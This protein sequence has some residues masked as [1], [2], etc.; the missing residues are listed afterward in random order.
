MKGIKLINLSQHPPWCDGWIPSFYSLHSPPL[1][2]WSTTL[3]MS[4]SI[5]SISTMT[6]HTLTVCLM[7]IKS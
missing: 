7:E 3:V 1:L 4:I 6:H 2:S 5:K